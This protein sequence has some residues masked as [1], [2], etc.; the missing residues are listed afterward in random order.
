MP[1][2]TFPSFPFPFRFS[3]GIDTASRRTICLT[4]GGKIGI[5]AH[6]TDLLPLGSILC[7]NGTFQ[8]WFC[9]QQCFPKVP[10]ERA[11]P[12]FIHHIAGAIQRQA[13]LIRAVIV[14]TVV[15]QPPD[16]RPLRSCQFPWYWTAH[17]RLPFA[18]GNSNLKFTYLPPVS[19]STTTA[20]YVFPVFSL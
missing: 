19:S 14:G 16:R 5:S 15:H 20:S 9:W 3:P 4:G 6:R 12:P 7:G 8:F 2:L 17:F 10:A 1:F 11:C 13:D 18:A